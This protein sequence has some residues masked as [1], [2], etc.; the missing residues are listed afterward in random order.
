[1]VEVIGDRDEEYHLMTDGL[2]RF[3]NKI[4]MTSSSELKKLILREFHVNPSSSHLGYH[5]TLT[6]FKKFYH[7]PNLKKEVVEFVARFLD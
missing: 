6:L 7:F 3:R 1:M 5:K 4:Y 2:V